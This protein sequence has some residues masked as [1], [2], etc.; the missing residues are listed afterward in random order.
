VC[1]RSVL[2]PKMRRLSSW[3]SCVRLTMVSRSDA[4]CAS[5]S[6]I[7]DLTPTNSTWSVETA[8]ASSASDNAD[9]LPLS[10]LA[11]CTYRCIHESDRQ[12]QADTSRW[13]ALLARLS[14]CGAEE[15][16]GQPSRP[17]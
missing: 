5:L 16:S 12:P 7:W 2:L 1:I 11:P 9:T 17:C 13:L 10:A 3:F 4:F 6:R 14:G 8:A 15:P